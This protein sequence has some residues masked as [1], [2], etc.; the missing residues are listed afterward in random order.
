MEWLDNAKCI[1]PVK[2]FQLSS[3]LLLWIISAV[4]IN[5]RKESQLRN[6]GGQSNLTKRLHRSHMW[7]VQIVFARWRQCAPR[8]NACFLGPTRLRIPNGSLIA[9]AIVAVHG[10]QSLY[11]TVGRPSSPQIAASRGGFGPSANI[12]P[13]RALPA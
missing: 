3:K 12:W 4:W 8:C 9:S 6:R 5:S 10:R 2:T 13:T 1:W 7:M 11:F